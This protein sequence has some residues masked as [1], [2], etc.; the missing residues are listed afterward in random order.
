TVDRVHPIGVHVVRESARAADTADE[1]H[2]LPA[3][4][5]LG[6][7]VAHR[8]ED[9]VV[10][11]ARAPAHLLVGGEV[12]GLLRFVGGGHPAQGGQLQLGAD[13]RFGVCA[14]AFAPAVPA[15]VTA[16]ALASDAFSSSRAPSVPVSASSMI[17]STSSARKALPATLVTDWMSTR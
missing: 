1:H 14:H 3:H 6:Q 2:V 12:L 15:M 4:P 11:A 7:E 5:Q 16:A 10:A 9:R 8:V 13:Q 17:A